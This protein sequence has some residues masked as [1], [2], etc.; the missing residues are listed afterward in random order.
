M[1][2]IPS[3]EPEKKSPF[4]SKSVYGNYV[5]GMTLRNKKRTDKGLRAL[6]IR[7]YQE[8]SAE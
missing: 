4:M 1:P 7:T 8:W 6:H 3:G 2:G 5:K